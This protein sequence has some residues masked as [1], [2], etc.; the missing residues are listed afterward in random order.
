MCFALECEMV[1]WRV[2]YSRSSGMQCQLN[3]ESFSLRKYVIHN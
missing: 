1:K 2:V 3:V